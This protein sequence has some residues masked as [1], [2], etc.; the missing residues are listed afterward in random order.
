MDSTEEAFVAPFR[1]HIFCFT[2]QMI[3][4]SEKELQF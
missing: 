3:V 2:T 4:F 1:Y